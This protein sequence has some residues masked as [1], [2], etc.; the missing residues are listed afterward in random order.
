VQELWKKI[1]WY[2]IVGGVGLIFGAVIV[3]AIAQGRYNRAVDELSANIVAGTTLNTGLQQEN[4]RLIEANTRLSGTV[5]ELQE[6]TS[7]LEQQIRDGNTEH[8]RQLDEARN[9]FGAIQAG[10]GTISE[11][12]SGTGTT[13]QGVSEGLEQ[14]KTLIKSLP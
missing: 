13:L 14:I 2:I 11:G 12:L 10:L 5:G 6:G 8:Q 3:F 7:R 1:K 9:K 4:F